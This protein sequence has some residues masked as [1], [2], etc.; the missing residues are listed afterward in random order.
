MFYYFKVF[1]KGDL[2]QTA[3]IQVAFW[4]REVVRYPPWLDTFLF[5]QRQLIKKLAD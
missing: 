4:L 1:C 5:N 3:T 2:Y